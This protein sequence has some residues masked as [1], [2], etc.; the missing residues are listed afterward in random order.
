[1]L[2]LALFWRSFCY[3]KIKFF[4]IRNVVA[5]IKTM[6][7]KKLLNKDVQLDYVEIELFLFCRVDIFA[8]KW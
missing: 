7:K 6:Y 1:M 8:G 4:Y 2:F 3:Y 5:D